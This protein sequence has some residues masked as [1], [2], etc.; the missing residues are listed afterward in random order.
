MSL[1]RLRRGVSVVAV[2]V[3]FV[4]AAPVQADTVTSLFEPPYYATGSPDLQQGWVAFG[5]AGSGC[6]L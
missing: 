6:A 3:P 5:S 4:V 1:T 2:C